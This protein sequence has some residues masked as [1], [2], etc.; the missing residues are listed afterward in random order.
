MNWKRLLGWMLSVLILVSSLTSFALPSQAVSPA[1][2]YNL[3]QTEIPAISSMP[4]LPAGAKI[5]DWKAR[6]LALDSFLFDWNWQ[7]TPGR[8][9]TTIYDDPVYGGFAIPS[10][11]GDT[12]PVDSPHKQEFITLMGALLAGSLL[13]VRKDVVNPYGEEGETYLDSAGKFFWSEDGVFTNFPDGSED[14]SVYND[15]WYLLLSNQ[16]FFRLASLYPGWDVRELQKSV[17][18]KM[19]GMVDVLGGQNCNFNQQAFDF[20][21][22]TAKAPGW[23]QPDAAAGTASILYYAY[24]IFGTEKYLT[25]AKYCM[26]YLETLNENPYYE[27]MLIDAVYLSAMMNA[28]VGTHYNAAKYLKWIT[29]SSSAVRNWGGIS[30]SQ[31]GRDISGL[32]GEARSDRQY[33]FFFN[34]VYPVTSILPTAK[35]DPSY[36]RAAGKWALNIA[37]SAR[38]FLPSEWPAE[39]QSNPEFKGKPEES[40]FA[41]EGFK[42]YSESGKDGPNVTES[43]V[44]FMATGDAMMNATSGWNAGKDVTNLGIY[45]SVY[46]GMLGALVEKTNVEY[47][48][49][50]DCNKTDYYQDSMYPTYLYYNPYDEAKTVEIELDGACDLYDSVTGTYLARNVS[51]RQSFKILAD[52]ARVLVL[53]PAGSTLELKG[54]ATLIDGKLVARSDAEVLPAPGNQSVSSIEISG[55]AAISN[56]GQPAQFS[57][58]V[59]PADAEDSRVR[60]SVVGKDKQPTDRA[61]IDRNGLLTPVKN[62]EIYVVA[63][64]MDGTG[65]LAEFPVTVSGQTLPSLSC[66]KPVTVSSQYE[67][68]GGARAVDENPSTRWI[69]DYGEAN[70]WIYVD[71]QATA[72]IYSIIL[73]WE[74]ARPP[75]YRLE[76][77][78]DA[79]NWT[80]LQSFSDG[81]NTAAVI[82]VEPEAP[83]S[84][85]YVRVYTETRSDWGASLYELSVNGSLRIDQP[86]T[87]ITVTSASGASEI[88]TRNRTLQLEAEVTPSNASDRRVEWCVF[89]ENGSETGLAEITSTGLLKPHQNGIVRVVA[90]SADGS[91]ISG[92]AL[93]AIS[94]QEMVNLC[95]G[96][97]ASASHSEPANH[98]SGAVDG[99]DTTRW[100][101]G[102]DNSG[103]YLTV[104]LGR[105]VIVGTAVL[106]WEAAYALQYKLQ[107]STDGV[108]YTDLYTQ[109]DGLGGT[110][111]ITFSPTEVRYLRMQGVKNRPGLGY[112]L[113]EFEAYGVSA[114]DIN[115]DGIA[116][117][118]DVVKLREVIRNGNATDIQKAAGDLDGSGTL[119]KNDVLLLLNQLGI[120]AGDVSGDG[121]VTPLDIMLIRKQMLSENPPSDDMLAAGDLDGSGSLDPLDI[122]LL[123][124]M[125]L[126]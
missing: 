38:Y 70:P 111:E 99:N 15:F 112:S 116:D 64:A 78:D 121:G 57:A 4:Q 86:V 2:G 5:I 49:K 7:N 24:K 126:S 23:R 100:A 72:S 119:D 98:P 69:A 22:M 77:S 108:T 94:G 59:L 83:V 50:L 1:A 106:T 35:Y 120:L 104:D 32:T 31:D 36:A 20:H 122:M 91:G 76:L 37:C 97:N 87:G 56:K 28:E 110:E 40:V 10:F 27:N 30:Y 13:G 48:L 95:E 82:T 118:G 6:G 65:V 60:W 29:E 124:K 34:S 25:Y 12:R 43:G 109:T 39:N 93:V 101:S 61:V 88:R 18:D 102:T 113:W 14:P 114:G 26:D 46:T 107:G 105:P 17:A 44:H 89:N 19:C 41:Y 11:Y 42:R 84:A 21:T 71:L 53:V 79:V 68:F 63:A 75:R 85:R 90:K 16:N 117:A 58:A 45:G 54:N 51:G 92:S 8:K 103:E 125:L 62:G 3:K 47:I 55:P 9:F 33:A 74:A 67:D 81:G 115:A 123:R 52:S 96:K 80:R 73:N 66:G